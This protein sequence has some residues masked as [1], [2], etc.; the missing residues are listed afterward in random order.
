MKA[1]VQHCSAVIDYCQGRETSK[2]EPVSNSHDNL[3]N[4]RRRGYQ[5]SALHHS[6]QRVVIVVR[7]RIELIV[8]QRAIIDARDAHNNSVE[9]IVLLAKSS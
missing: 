5:F 2:I 7:D 4:C 3:A 6:V 9:H 8:L 1:R